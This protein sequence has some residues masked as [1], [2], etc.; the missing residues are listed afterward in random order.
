MSLPPS[1]YGN[2]AGTSLLSFFYSVRAHWR[3]DGK[4]I[5]IAKHWYLKR[6]ADEAELTFEAWYHQNK[7]LQLYGARVV[8]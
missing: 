3:I 8:A 6:L 4:R 1:G 7:N 5:E 2:F